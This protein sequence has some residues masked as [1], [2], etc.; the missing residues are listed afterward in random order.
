MSSLKD[1]TCILWSFVLLA[2]AVSAT[3]CYNPEY[4]LT[5]EF[6]K[7]IS[8]DGD[9]SAPFGNSEIISVND[10]LGLGADGDNVLKT[11]A[12]GNYH[13]SVNGAG[14]ASDV[15][16]PIFTFSKDLVRDGG[17]SAVISK[18]ELPLPSSGTVPSTKYTKHFKAST[19]PLTVEEDI[20]EE[21]TGVRAVE[22]SASIVISVSLSGGTATLSDLVLDFPDYFLFAEPPVNV[23]FDYDGNKVT[24]RSREVNWAVQSFNLGI[25]GI[26]LSKIPAGQGFDLNRHKFILEDV[27]KLDAFDVSAV[28]SDLGN[29]V[30]DVPSQ[31]SADITLRISSLDVK[32]A[33]VKV[34]PSISIEPVAVNVGTMPDF[35][36]GE[37]IVMDLENPVFRLGVMNGTPLALGLDADIISYK[38]AEMRTAHVGGGVQGGSPVTLAASSESRIH[39]SRTGEGAE[40]GMI[41]VVVP[42]LSSVI[43]NVPELIGIGNVSLKAA[44]EFVTLTP[45][46]RYSVSY[47]Y[48]MDAPL[49]F[50]RDLHVVYDYDFTGWNDTF[51]SDDFSL[52]IRD[53]DVKFDFVSTIP[54]SMALLASAIDMD[55]NVLSGV[56]VALD[57]S[58]AAGDVGNP[59]VTPMTLNLKGDAASMR[60]LD[61]IR[62]WLTAGNP[63]DFEG[64]CLNSGQGVQFRNMKLHVQGRAD[65]NIDNL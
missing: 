56:H 61:G 18:S 19:T 13:I 51:G 30:E 59:S 8:I 9:V 41:S 60:K 50:G 12:S 52:E 31:I 57:G 24:I 27:I 35:L 2:A 40:Q 14:A 33:E 47:D 22:A 55:G 49:A 17:Y 15:S 62:V 45:G 4:D 23:R 43:S 6:D 37:G 63:G 38:G 28:L 34:N 29:K 46:A 58:A 39:V 44:D 1:S 64:V 21:I 54:L 16:L 48:E 65:M 3:S 42:E 26:D 11:D 20:P 25:A 5:R 7:G 10:F 36:S 53:A 32:S